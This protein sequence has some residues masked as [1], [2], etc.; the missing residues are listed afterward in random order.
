M[1]FEDS[2]ENIRESIGVVEGRLRMIVSEH[3]ESENKLHGKLEEENN[4]G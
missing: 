1:Q 4:N 2:Q 3:K